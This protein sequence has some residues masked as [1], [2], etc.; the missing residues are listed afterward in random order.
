MPGCAAGTSKS[1]FHKARRK[2]RRLLT[3]DNAST[4]K[5]LKALQ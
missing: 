3:S 2:L 1:Q 5:M 4:Q